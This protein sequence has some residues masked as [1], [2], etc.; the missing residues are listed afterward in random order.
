MSISGDKQPDEALTSPPP[1]VD[2]P[3][4]RLAHELANLLDGSLRNVGLV[5]SSL[6]DP[7]GEGPA[8]AADDEDLIR[9]LEVANQAMQHMATLIQR[10]LGRPKAMG[11]LHQQTRTLGETIH[12]AVHLL[13]PVAAARRIVIDVDIAAAVAGLPAGPVYPIIANAVRNSIEAM[14]QRP[15]DTTFQGGRI[16]VA[17]RLIEGMV[18]LTIRDNGPGLSAELYDESGSFIQGGTTKHGG[19]GLGLVLVREITAN[20]GGT[21]HLAN[22]PAGGT[23]LVIRYPRASVAQ[24][25]RLDQ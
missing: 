2:D 19:P 13:S 15:A 3:H 1:R 24:A 12:S 5:M 16:E 22:R 6:R 9:R 8:R 23:E 18:E 4:A 17:A 21:F 7:T 10:W 11:S 20:L 14:I 25:P